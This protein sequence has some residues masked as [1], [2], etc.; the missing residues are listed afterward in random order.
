MIWRVIKIKIYGEERNL[1]RAVGIL[2][3]SIQNKDNQKK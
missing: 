1:H 2:K 3:T